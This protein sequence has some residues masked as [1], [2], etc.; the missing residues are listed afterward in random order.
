MHRRRGVLY[1]SNSEKTSETKL[2]T[3]AC[4]VAERATT[5]TPTTTHPPSRSPGSRHPADTTSLEK[6][7]A[8]VQQGQDKWRLVCE[9]INQGPSE[10]RHVAFNFHNVQNTYRAH[11]VNTSSV[12]SAWVRLLWSTY[13]QRGFQGNIKPDGLTGPFPGIQ[14][15]V[16]LTKELMLH[17]RLPDLRP[18]QPQILDQ[19]PPSPAPPVLVPAPST[20]TPDSKERG[21]KMTRAFLRLVH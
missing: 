5:S 14:T 1:H 17:V 4:I 6:I 3:L 10:T 20:Q 7:G 18:P 11:C 9:I 21:E 13:P 2:P 16:P 12:L 8:Q 19:T 15:A